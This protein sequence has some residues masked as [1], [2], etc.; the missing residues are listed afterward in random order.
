MKQTTYT[1]IT[2][3]R[4]DFEFNLPET[5]AEGVTKYRPLTIRT[6]GQAITSDGGKKDVINLATV[7]QLQD[8]PMTAKQIYSA[9][10]NVTNMHVRL[11]N[12]IKALY[13]DAINDD[14]SV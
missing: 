3:L 9:I 8:V 11:Q 2:N 14:V 4:I 5:D 13:L 1:D 10:G 6:Q 7:G 12:A